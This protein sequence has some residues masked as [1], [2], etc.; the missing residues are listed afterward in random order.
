M[1][2]LKLSPQVGVFLE[3]LRQSLLN[4]LLI[5]PGDLLNKLMQGRELS[6]CGCQLQFKASLLKL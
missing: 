6:P 5:D 1:E 3:D 4:F 2:L